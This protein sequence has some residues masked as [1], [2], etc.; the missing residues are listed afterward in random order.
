M[1]W[2]NVLIWAGLTWG[3]CAATAG[4]AAEEAWS[5]R[6][7]LTERS[8]WG[9]LN[10]TPERGALRLRLSHPDHTCQ[11]EFTLSEGDTRF[12]LL[13]RGFFDDAT[14]RRV[15]TYPCPS[16]AGPL[17]W[18]TLKR[19]ADVWILTVDDRPVARLP[20]LWQGAVNVE[21]PPALQP[22]E[23]EADEY[24]Q[25]LGSFTFE[26]NFLVPAGSAFPPTWDI[27]SGIWRLHSVTG[28]ISGSS[29]G[30][31]L[32]RQ[33]KP[34]KSP[35]FYTLEGGGT[36][37]IVLAGEPFYSRYV[38]RA[39]V[40][41]NTGTNGLVFL[42]GEHGGYFAF[43]ARTD[44]VSDRLI[45]DLWQQPAAPDAPR[46][47][48][49][50]VQTELPA[51]QWL[52]LEVQTFD[53]RILCRA[54]NIE[55][56]RH[57]IGLP[58][59]GRFGLFANM[60]AGET[61][62]FDDVT[63]ASHQDR[64][65]DSPEDV[66]FATR[67]QSPD[68]RS[69]QRHDTA[70]LYFPP[71]ATTT[72]MWA[73]G[74]SD[75]GPLRQ[76]IRV[77]ATTDSFL[78]GLT[79]GGSGD[80]AAPYRFTCEQDGGGRTFRLEHVTTNG[81]VLLDSFQMPVSS[82]RVILALDAL[83]PH[84]LRAYADDLLVCFHRPED[85]PGGELGVLAVTP[86]DLFFTAPT[87]T[88][89]ETGLSERFEKNPLYVN[90]PFMRHWAS[91]EGQWITFKNGMT[92]FK[93]DITGAVRVRLPVVEE[94]ELH[95]GVPEGLS[96]GLCRVSV[97][98][99]VI[100]VFTPESGTNTAFEVS[101]DQVPEVEFNNTK[102]RLFTLG[103]EGS[104]LWLGGD[105]LLLAQTHLHAPL[106]GRRMRIS[107]MT[108]D[109]LSRT[110]VK[111]DNVFDTLFTE[112][113]Y[114]WT[115]NGGRWEVINRFYCEPTWSHMN[116]ESADSLAALWSKYVFRGDFSI[117]F[118][119]GM[120]MGWYARPGD[121]N[122]TMMSRSL[123]TGDGYTAIATG[124]DPDHSQLYSRLIRNG[125]LLDLSTKYLV[126]RAR[127]G[128]ARQGYQPLVAGGRD[129]HGA[130]YGMQLRR[131]GKTLH[132][133]YDNEDVFRI[134]D[135]D[136]LQEGALGIWTYRNS[137][138]VARIKIAAE[139]IRPRPFA[140]RALPPAAPPPT[141]PAAAPADTGIRINGR[142]A[143]PLTPDFWQA[144]D[145][146]S[147]PNVRFRHLQTAR[148]EMY[149][150][151]LLGAGSFLVRCMLP[152]AQPDKLLGWRFEIARHPQAR[153]NFEFATVKEDGKGGWTPIQH[154]TY[155]LCGSN[156]SRGPRKICGALES[157]PASDP[158]GTNRVWTPVEIWVPSEIIRANQAVQ[159]E[160][161]GNLQPSDVQQG[162]EGN[163]PH[164]WYAIRHFRE[165]HRGIPTVSGPPE[166]RAEIASLTQLING[167]SPGELQMVE[168]PAAL[169]SR[170][171][172]IEW[173]VPERAKFGLLAQ[174]DPAVLGSIVVTPTHP[175]PSPM[176][177]PKQVQVDAQ[178]APFYTEGNTIRILVPLNILQPGRMTLALE[179]YDGRFFRQVVPMRKEDSVNSPPVLLSLTMPEGAVET[180]EAR[181]FDTTPHKMAA[182][183]A[184][185]VTDPRR[186]GVLAFSN[187]G[188]Y[189]RRLTG[190]LFPR[191]D[192]AATPLLQFR[193]KGDPMAIVSLA[194]GEFAF[195][196]SE[197][198]NTSVRFTDN[199][200]AEMDDTW[201]VWTGIPSDSVGRFPLAK[202]I[203]LPP[204]PIRLASRQTRDQTGL[205]STLRIDDLT[206]GPAAGPNRPFAFKA[207]YADP[208]GVAEIAY[209]ILPG[210]AVWDNRSADEQQKTAWLPGKNAAV[211]EPDLTALADGIH[212]LVVRARDGQGLWSQPT[213]VPFLFDRKPPEIHHA[214]TD[215]DHYNGSCLTITL[216]D[217]V[218]PP[219]LNTLR[220]T[221]LGTP[222]NL[223]QDNG[224][225][226]VGQGKIAFELDWIWLLREQLAAVKHGTTLPLSLGGI[227]DAAGNA[228][229]PVKIEIPV[230][231]EKDT[232]PPTILPTAF[233]TNMLWCEPALTT[234]D[235]FFTESQNVQATTGVTP[236][237]RALEITANGER[238][239]YIR[240]TFGP[241]W[242]PDIYP[243]LAISFRTV[244]EPREG[245]PFTLAFNTGARR[246]RGIKEAHTL[247]LKDTNHLA[248]VTGALNLQTGVWNDVLIDVRSFL[249]QETDEHKNTP[250]IT[251]LSLF[252][253]HK[254]KGSAVQIRSLSILSPWHSALQI[255]IRAYDLSTVAG[256]QWK[257]GRSQ[258]TGIRPANLQL[259]PDDP[260]WFRFRLQ[261]GRG[262]LTD[263]W[264]IPVPPGS[265]NSN[266]ALPGLEPVVF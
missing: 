248:Y 239:S 6:L 184:V 58:P 85:Q 43:T 72:Q 111:R 214:L 123:S 261:D 241:T 134:E 39:A 177:P 119:A 56:I 36:N 50:G 12:R 144:Y 158:A 224:F 88:S 247:N 222:I 34:E 196:F 175:W 181:P 254:A 200:R 52:L 132:Y 235:P 137:M 185:E 53:D 46:L 228:L 26:D 225:C 80:G 48:L 38:F 89:R 17:H 172:V 107:G 197:A 77:V 124:W 16:L 55:V 201:R 178:P 62:R 209:A 171:P 28:S 35:N 13:P 139:S 218:A 25:R 238:A 217:P 227:T 97:K 40:Q 100:R 121:L 19:H 162:L 122:L 86:G 165:I 179:L 245:R 161:F 24:T 149:V 216:T 160:G 151:S 115:I 63:A 146:V 29:G 251:Y 70:W 18:I 174:S 75:D 143:Q 49:A 259:P 113:L 125:S 243:W 170:R 234:L 236:D 120:R 136:P 194:F 223:K 74:S 5:T 232:R 133:I 250:D 157:L 130:W 180:F 142:V 190:Q 266:P 60:P 163:P 252:F 260:L 176:L 57:K 203:S 91:P 159:I 65:F 68:V 108:L 215:V 118:Y 73:Y 220:L 226:T 192:I 76:E 206:C 101:A 110:L 173:A 208:D 202:R 37:A 135:P 104:V 207:D 265:Q 54:D 198:F 21:H 237:G 164:A 33:P 20:E 258:A 145:T 82:N 246:P 2:T 264:M 87:V 166:K 109:N 106:H 27:Q 41:H 66:T 240:H 154:W 153:V 155:V 78:C 23:A 83:R 256:L 138:M 127:T 242:D 71:S 3:C 94:M 99:G 42:A 95:L 140:F 205:H 188:V 183:V 231:L 93:G 168:L 105:T 244:G 22:P 187:A 98:K 15:T 32:A 167:L 8:E 7:D 96:N 147:H 131:V 219:V 1:N 59:G 141:E 14:E 210:P 84:E 257:G 150:T 51:G 64:L 114:N 253:R 199:A 191:F 221:H 211:I 169:D 186:G 10:L 182:R 79:A 189:G 249:L 112:S 61:T 116:G 212:H 233:P 230:N 204:A 255:P 92:W 9:A 47:Y 11:A 67:R 117:E 229:P 213:D 263:T 156:E 69:L 4:L 31:Q 30:Y 126:P 129:I 195:T 102:L 81:T 128:L 44:P 193:Y 45:L 262:N 148:P 152:P 90:D 103:L